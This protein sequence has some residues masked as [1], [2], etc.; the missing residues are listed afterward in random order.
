MTNDTK[1]KQSK[2]EPLFNLVKDEQDK[3]NIVVG[4]YRVC[5]KTF[6]TFKQAE[7]YIGS[8]PYELIFNTTCLIIENNNKQNENIKETEPQD[9]KDK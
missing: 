3:V 9:R 5:R 2:I 1:F 6:D 4:N 8:K 7:Q